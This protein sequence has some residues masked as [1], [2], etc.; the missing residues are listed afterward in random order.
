MRSSCR[1]HLACLVRYPYAV[2]AKA[3]LK[4]MRR[5]LAELPVEL[6]PLLAGSHVDIQQQI[7]DSFT[8]PITWNVKGMRKCVQNIAAAV[9]RFHDQASSVCETAAKM[10]AHIDG[11]RTCE[12]TQSAIRYDS[13][14]CAV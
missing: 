9:N 10:E 14:L 1:T 8:Q 4:T 12:F 13:M 11:L 6:R 2:S 3:S 5:T 7:T